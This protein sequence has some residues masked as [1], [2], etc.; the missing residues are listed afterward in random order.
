[1]QSIEYEKW[2]RID[3]KPQDALTLAHIVQSMTTDP[4]A[5]L[6]YTDVI[7][8]AM[9]TD[10]RNLQTNCTPAEPTNAA[11][12]DKKDS[13]LAV[14]EK[15]NFMLT[16][17]AA[18][19]L[20]G[21]E[22]YTILLASIPGMANEISTVLLECLKLYNSRTQHL[23]LGTGAK[24]TAGLINIKQLALAS[25]SPS[26]F[27]ALIPY[28]RECVRR[29]PSI[30]ASSMAEYDRLK[31]LFQNHRSSIHDKLIEIMASR[32]TLHIRQ[33]KKIKWD[34][35]D[36]VQRNVSPHMETLTKEALTLQRV[37]S[38]YLPTLSVKMIVG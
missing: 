6:G 30:T 19:A 3:F 23:I 21:I 27:T 10:Q 37:L 29:R 38:M 9:K 11:Q 33:M 32:A 12:Q 1:M 14:I 18:F 20:R 31:R 5:W 34:D 16:D 28:L 22:Q 26:F 13:T 36:E 35:K 17:S 2:E 4:P 24:I 7:I 25:Q 15:E 8:V